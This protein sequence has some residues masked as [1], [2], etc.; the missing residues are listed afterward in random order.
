MTTRPD[1]FEPMKQPWENY[2][3]NKDGEIRSNSR[4][5]KNPMGRQGTPRKLPQ[6]KLK[7]R[8]NGSYILR[9]AGNRTQKTRTP[10][11]WLA[12]H[13]ASKETTC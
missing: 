2:S 13:V 8:K 12:V 4:A 1:T 11:Q 3:I 7:P 10:A 9:H 6:K 5:L